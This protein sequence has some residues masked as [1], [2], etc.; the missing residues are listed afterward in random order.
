MS[1]ARP[2]YRLA[3]LASIAVLTGYLLT[4]AP[5]VTFWDAGEFIAAARTLGIPHPP[6]T[7]LFVMLAHTWGLL[8]PFGEYAWRLN[9]L[10]AVCAAAAAGCWFLVAHAT[11][12]RM[13]DDLDAS[14]RNVLAIGAGGSAA[15]LT[16]F[17]FTNWQNA[18]ET[19]VY[20]VAMLSIAL[21]AWL[22]MRWREH[23]STTTGARMMLLALYLGAM[24]IGNHLLALLIG[25]AVV[26]AWLMESRRAPLGTRDEA[27]AEWVRIAMFAA[28][29]LLLIGFGLGS[30]TLTAVS[31]GLVLVAGV[32][33]IRTRQLSF[34]VMALLIA[35]VGVTPYLFLLFRARQ[36]PWLNEADPS[37]WDALLGVIRRAQYPIRTPLDDP[38][39]LHGELNP[40]RTFTILGYQLAN[41]VQYFDWQWAKSIGVTIAPSLGRFLV[42]MGAFSLGLR[43]A[44]AQRN[45]DR[46][47]FGLLAMLWLV[48]GLGLVV[49]MN[50]KPGTTL[51]YDLWP[52][53][54]DHEVRERDYFFVV[55]F[56]AW[57][58]W[59][60]I[61]LADLIRTLMPR[62]RGAARGA[63][64]SLFALAAV[65]LV[66]N[67]RVASRH[68]GPEATF[69]RDF[70]RALLQSV[71]PGG[72]L[73]TWG[74]N[75]TFPVWYAQAVE[76]LRR[77]VTVVCL[78]L[79]ETPWYMRQL[80]D[81]PRVPVDPS[82]LAS[83]WRDAAAPLETGP[84]HSLTDAMIAGFVPQ[85]LAE[86]LVV[87][88]PNGVSVTVPKGSAVF[89]KDL[90]VLQILRQ[91]AGRRPVSWS[92]TA[93]QKTFDL[94]PAL[95]QQGLVL[96]LPIGTID[97]TRLVAGAASGP[98][99]AALDLVT[100]RRLMAENWSF[101]S[102]F[103]GDVLS[104]DGNIR[105]MAAT[106]ALP[107]AQ[108]GVGLLQR[109]DTTGALAALR[110]AAHLSDQP[111]IRE[112]LQ[113]LQG[114]QA[115][116]LSTP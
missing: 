60:A 3:L 41:Y 86:D 69:A 2:P 116:P 88:L 24:S 84:L 21:V 34:T 85:R 89:G 31:I 45:R 27:A 104:L 78:A 23:R 19:E 11:V 37:T 111:A 115:P 110:T 54:S 71:P 6:G 77:D 80:R 64:L 82:S 79:A 26:V 95:I 18:V 36:A 42:T 46:S 73:F 1:T 38:T 98:G 97:S 4:L 44:W 93:A 94:G 66:L 40:G 10:S 72:I 20:S 75:D 48:T 76:G 87:Q 55:S 103:T 81:T 74:D 102:L 114:H 39:V 35:F 25:P 109:G 58:A 29:W 108:V 63:M 8:V 113:A 53:G 65:P 14:P 9:L 107:Y 51:G 16:A 90:M 22:A 101:G 12:L 91:N 92:V 105:G 50:F 15:L 68:G 106:I 5:S 43:G 70:A 47:G 99:G 30:V 28:I 13:Y 33:A 49:Y 59:V 100:T 83:V 7:P 17:T 62:V 96:T 57:G 67:A 112:I 56:V 32:F 61:G 52:N